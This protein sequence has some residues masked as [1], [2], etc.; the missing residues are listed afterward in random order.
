MPQFLVMMK[1]IV[2]DVELWDDQLR[3][4]VKVAFDEVAG[5]TPSLI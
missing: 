1:R 3:D 2:K 5:G 4:V